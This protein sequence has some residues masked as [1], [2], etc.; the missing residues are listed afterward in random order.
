MFPASE[1]DIYDQMPKTTS[2]ACA[3]KPFVVIIYT[4]AQ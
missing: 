3:I 1:D 2:G 4:V